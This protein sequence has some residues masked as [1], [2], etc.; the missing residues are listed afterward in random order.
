MRRMSRNF[1][2]VVTLILVAFAM[3]ADVK[4]QRDELRK[5]LSEAPAEARGSDK[6]KW[7]DEHRK[8][9]EAWLNK[10]YQKQ[11]LRLVG[12]ATAVATEPTAVAEATMAP[13]TVFGQLF[14]GQLQYT[15][16]PESR[17]ELGKLKKND[18]I[19]AQGIV[20]SIRLRL[21]SGK[22]P[23]LVINVE[24]IDCTVIVPSK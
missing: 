9:L 3:A 10:K 14:N 23:F 7:T 5:I 11:T 20:K 6:E 16:K 15:F 17:E 13:V 4:P 22:K 18:R 2:L 24:L 19:D 1:V 21:V 12:Q 8:A